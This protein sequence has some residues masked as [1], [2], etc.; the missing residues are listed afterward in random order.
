MPPWAA[1]CINMASPSWRAPTTITA[2]SQGQRIWPKRHQRYRRGNGAPGV[3]D[4]PHA[5]QRAARGQQAPFGGREDILGVDASDN[6]H[7][8]F[9]ATSDDTPAGLPVNPPLGLRCESR[10]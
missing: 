1:S 6:R 5:S 9:L 7:L 10:R 3:S 8:I 4:K 2:I